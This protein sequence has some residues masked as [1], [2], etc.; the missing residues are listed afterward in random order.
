MVERH[1]TGL[2]ERRPEAVARRQRTGQRTAQENVD[3][4]RFSLPS[5][6]AA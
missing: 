1:V 2:D 4:G 5:R 6:S 3:K